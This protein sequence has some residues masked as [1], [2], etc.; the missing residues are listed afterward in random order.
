MQTNK[1]GR[2]VGYR[3]SETSRKA[4]SQSKIGQKHSQQT[5]DKISRTLIHYFRRLNPLSDEIINRYCRSDDDNICDWITDIREELDDDEGIKTDRSL[6]NIRKIEISCGHN[7]EY[8]SHDLTPETILL[9]K[10]RCEEL[11]IKLED[12]M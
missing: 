6:R 9:L 1:R 12:Y 10:E 11:G 7:V 2:P 3:L 8:F 5:K 4:I